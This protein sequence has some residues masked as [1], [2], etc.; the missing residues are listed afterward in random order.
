MTLLFGLIIFITILLVYFTI[1]IILQQVGILEK[2][3]INL[4]GPALLLRTLRGRKF[5][6]KLAN[7]KKFWKSFGTFAVIFCFIM[8]ILM[9]VILIWQAW[10]VLG[11]TPE[12]REA[13][14]GPE[15]ALVIPG[16]NPILPL[17]YIG[18]II[19]ALALAIIVHEFS[20]GILTYVADLKVKSL[21]ILY[22]I[23][24]IGAFCEPDEEALK[25]TKTAKRMRLLTADIGGE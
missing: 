8:M 15:I 20:H 1:V 10:A 7:A 5:L 6:Q 2:Y 25:K 4:Y 17:E 21:G 12:Q 19:L 16:I 24:P 14:P 18:Y 11:F 13:M 3:K 22:M 9:V 23:I